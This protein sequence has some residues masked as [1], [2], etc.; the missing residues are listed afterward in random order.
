MI[1]GFALCDN[2]T[3]SKFASQKTVSYAGEMS[4]SD[5]LAALRN[6]RKKLSGCSDELE[7]KGS[8]AWAGGEEEGDGELSLNYHR[9]L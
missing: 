1:A 9:D 4:V 5:A 6:K 2:N 7:R 8:P 3:Y